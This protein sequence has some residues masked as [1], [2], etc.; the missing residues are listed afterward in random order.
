VKRHTKRRG[1]F[2]RRG[3]RKDWVYR[4]EGDDIGMGIDTL[5]GSY[6]PIIRTLTA[7]LAT[8]IVLILYD[9]MDRQGYI[10]SS[11]AAGGNFPMLPAS[12]RMEPRRP[13]VHRVEG[14]I[15]MEPTTW[16][17][18]NLMAVGARLAWYE[19]DTLSGSLSLQAE[20]SMWTQG[21]AGT[22]AQ[23]QPAVFANQGFIR[24]WRW[25]KGFG[26]GSSQHFMNPHVFW[27]GSMKGRRSPSSK[28]C[29]AILVEAESTS[30]N[31]R[32]QPW[33]RSLMSA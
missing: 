5:Q 11:G 4:G 9:S 27:Q 6:S 8:S 22:R 21:A 1:G 12:G 17:S 2:F 32:V 25:Y 33:L 23:D 24:E 10:Q 16:A 14:E 3:P 30:V 20:Y 19:Q 31:M 13:T 26:D 28:H 15:Y 18:G 7:G 29:L